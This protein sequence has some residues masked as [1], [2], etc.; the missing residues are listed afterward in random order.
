MSIECGNPPI[1][2]VLDP[3]AEDLTDIPVMVALS[4]SAGKG[5]YD[6]SKVFEALGSAAN[7]K[8]IAVT[9]DDRTTQCYVEIKEWDQ[10]NK[11]AWLWVKVPLISSVQPTRLYLYYDSNQPD[12]TVYV[13]DTGEPAAQ[14]VWTNGYAGVWHK[15]SG[16]LLL[17]SSPNGNHATIYGATPTTGPLGACYS[18]D[19]VDDRALTANPVDLAGGF[20]C[21]FFA[22]TPAPHYGG[23]GGNNQF[24]ARIDPLTEHPDRLAGFLKKS[25]GTLLQRP[26]I[27][28]ITGGGSIF[29]AVWT[30]D[31]KTFASHGNGNHTSSIS[32]NVALSTPTAFNI[33][34]PN[35]VAGFG[36][37]DIYL[38]TVSSIARSP[39]WIAITNLA[40][41]DALIT[42]GEPPVVAFSLALEGNVLTCT[43][44]S[45]GE[46]ITG[47]LWD[48]GD[49]I[50][51]TEQN[52]VHVYRQIGTY[53]VT[54]QVTGIA[55]TTAP[56]TGGHEPIAVLTAILRIAVEG[57]TDTALPDHKELSGGGPWPIS[58]VD[59]QTHVR[60]GG[61]LVVQESED[62]TV[63][64]GTGAAGASTGGSPHI[65]I[66]GIPVCREGDVS[67][68]P[69]TMTGI[70]VTHNDHVFDGSA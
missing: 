56:S 68:A 4:A 61:R 67:S 23:L 35:I 24:G 58:P 59:R 66:N 22:R 32:A 26:T 2:L 31:K 51:S 70:T 65:F 47:W 49:G 5:G 62:F 17:D 27:P 36:K 20:T 18:Y 57:D 42:Y 12:N 64:C 69:H 1:A 16:G 6:H 34:G 11:K 25:D 38:A 39:A 41:R 44:M 53:T 19:G 33:A 15:P 52:P 3:A 28:Y 45:T 60:I 8:K 63:H 14:Q 21:E 46:G 40:L 10:T 37:Y 43:D 48:F 7:R 9:T 30:W 55:G 29:H 13:G 50:I 54:L